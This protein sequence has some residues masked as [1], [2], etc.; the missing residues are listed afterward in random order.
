MALQADQIMSQNLLIF[1]SRYPSQNF[2][3]LHYMDIENL[4]EKTFQGH[5]TGKQSKTEE[6]A[7]HRHISRLPWCS[8]KTQLRSHQQL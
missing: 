6:E 5:S 7:S 1:I 4:P 3:N 2:L 8:G